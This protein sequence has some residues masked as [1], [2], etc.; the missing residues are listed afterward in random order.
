MARDAVLDQAGEFRRVDDIHDKSPRLKER[1]VVVDAPTERPSSY[2]RGHM[3][4]RLRS[5][6]LVT[7]VSACSAPPSSVDASLEDAGADAGTEDS[8]VADAGAVDGGQEDGGA[9]DS[10]ALDAG[11]PADAG[12]WDAGSSLCPAPSGAGAPFRLRAAAANLTSGNCQSWNPGPGA[13]ILQGLAPDVVMIQEFNTYAKAPSLGCPDTDL[14]DIPVLV[15]RLFPDAGYSWARG[16]TGRIPNGVLSRW[17]IVASGDWADPRVTDRD[18][19]WAQVDLPG[20]RDLWVV[21][22]HLLTSSASERTLEGNALKAQ[23]DA[24][25]PRGDFL[26]VG[27]DFNTTNTNENVFSA[28]EPRVVSGG[29]VPVDQRGNPGTNANRNKPYDQ[30]LASPCLAASQVPVVIGAQ[31]FDAGLVFDSRVYTPLADVAPVL[32]TDSD[33][34]NMQHMAV[35]KDFLVAP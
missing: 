2:A 13:R 6:V 7:L 28:L 9:P 3:L 8:G 26:L 17:P 27:G 11:P 10:G 34:P 1:T 22:V 25:V 33:A 14:A 18:F 4:G 29:E 19:T 12:S 5:V 31:S 30:V 16:A 23:L 21:S 20:P 32:A 35:V 15:E 24:L